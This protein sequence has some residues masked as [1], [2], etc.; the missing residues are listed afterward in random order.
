M[1]K[2]IALGLLVFTTII[3]A[4]FE[5]LLE[6]PPQFIQFTG[7]LSLLCT[8]ALIGSSLMIKTDDVSRH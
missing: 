1:T 2:F 4:V 6:L 3:C 7:L 8:F 5:G